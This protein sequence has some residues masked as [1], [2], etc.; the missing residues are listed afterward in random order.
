VKHISF[1]FPM[2]REAFLNGKKTV[3]RRLGWFSLE[4]G[5]VLMAVE[6]SQG[7]KKGEK[8]KRLGPIEVLSVSREPLDSITPRDVELEGLGATPPGVFVGEFCKAN[9]CTPDTRV[10][11]IEFRRIKGVAR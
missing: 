10:T 8:V 5:D 3:T 6:K 11:R 9:R 2:T 1:S 7:L 4:P